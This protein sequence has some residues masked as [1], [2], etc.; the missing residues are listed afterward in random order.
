MT[1]TIRST[2][3]S[4]SGTNVMSPKPTEPASTTQS[5]IPHTPARLLRAR[6]VCDRTGLS[7][8]TIWR[9]ERRGAFPLH[10]RISANAVGWLED[11]V[12]AWILSRARDGNL[13]D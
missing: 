5:R 11:D 13:L 6:T 3:R 10:R 1:L 12:D 2:R 4:T 8:S 7:R 9:L